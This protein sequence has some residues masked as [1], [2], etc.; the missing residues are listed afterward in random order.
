MSGVFVIDS[1]PAKSAPIDLESYAHLSGLDIPSYNNYQGVDLLIGQ[2]HAEA[3]LPLE[4]RK[5]G[6][7]EPFAVRSILG[8]CL[9]GSSHYQ[10]VSRKVISHF[11][12]TLRS[13]VEDE[14]HQLWKLE[15]EGLEGASWSE[16]DK[17]VIGLWDK[18]CKMVEGHYELPIPWKDCDDS[19]PNNYV[20]AKSR[21]GSLMKRL[22]K[23]GLVDRYQKE[24]DK[25]IDGGYAEIVPDDEIHSVERVWYL[26]HHAVITDKKPDKL[27]VVYDCA[28]RYGGKSLNERCKQGPNLINKLVHVLLR[29]RLHRFAVQADIEAMYNQVRIPSKDKDALRFLWCKD[30][31]IV[32]LRMT[33]HLFGGVWCS[34][35]STYA[36]R[37]TLSDSEGVSDLV[38]ETI[39]RAFY[40]DDC[41]KSVPTKS[42]AGDVIRDV[43]RVISCGGFKLTKFVVNDLETLRDIPEELRAKEV[44][45]LG[46]DAVGKV[47]GIHWNIPRDIFFFTVRVGEDSVITRRKMLSVVASIFDPLGLA[48]PVVLIGK[49]ILLEV[50][51]RQVGWDEPVPSDM[52]RQWEL[53]VQSMKWLEQS[54]LEIPRCITPQGFEDAVVELHHFSDASERA[55]GCCSYIRCINRIGVI[56]TRL[57]ISRNKVAPIKQCTIPRLELQAAVLAA[58]MDQV[59]RTELDVHIDQ[60]YFWVDSEIVL[61]YIYNEAKRFHVFVGNRVSLIRQLT[62]PSQWVH[63]PGNINPADVV[64]RGQ[65]VSK[66]DQDTWFNGPSFLR[67]YKS[68]WTWDVSSPCELSPDDP[69]VK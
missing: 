28:S 25:L 42:E 35:S 51:R 10:A 59:L 52:G 64:S 60:S 7:G 24:I 50:A 12:T 9:N 8:W 6:P 29:F 39:E 68:E 17:S 43:P 47:L 36:L 1:I 15:N 14:I 26:P 58:K 63:I 33:S 54:S 23:Q 27:R 53:W 46:P 57:V 37:R 45:E 31:N 67:E 5:G 32:Y 65:T 21:L 4:I 41:L 13:N 34:S 30:G 61:K 2:D 48:G 20:V 69:E 49:L 18:E 66:L 44:K 3:F 38:R 56:S 55:Y 16:E 40:V 22:D 19:L 62:M 11:V